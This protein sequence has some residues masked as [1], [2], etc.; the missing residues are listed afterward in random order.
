MDK[1]HGRF[2]WDIN[3]EVINIEKHGVSFIDAIEVFRDRN[4]K[5]IIDEHHDQKEER[6][7]CIGQVKGRLLTVRFTYRKEKVR[8]I[9]AGYWRMGGKH[10]NE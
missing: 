2:V 6:F 3:K 9:G 7:F 10:Y 8:I 4:R 5:I 1:E